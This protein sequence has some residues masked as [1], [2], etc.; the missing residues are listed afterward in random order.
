MPHVA[1]RKR[2]AHK[3]TGETITE[4]TEMLT[5]KDNEPATLAMKGIF[6]NS[7]REIFW[8][9]VEKLADQFEKQFNACIAGNRGNIGYMQLVSLKQVTSC[10][11]KFENLT[12]GPDTVKDEDRRKLDPSVSKKTL[13]GY[14]KKQKQRTVGRLPSATDN[15]TGR[16][17]NSSGK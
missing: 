14:I 6:K 17:S 12:P 1:I 13:N 2:K 4:A 7:S 8:A 9:P 15:D 5:A 11:N 3:L 16:R 10:V